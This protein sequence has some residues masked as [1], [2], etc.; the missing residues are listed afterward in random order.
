MRSVTCLSLS[1]AIKSTRVPLPMRWLLSTPGWAQ[2]VSTR[3]CLQFAQEF[4]TVDVYRGRKQA[5]SYLDDLTDGV[6]NREVLLEEMVMLWLANLNPAFA[7]YDD[8]FAHDTLKQGSAYQDIIDRLIVFFDAQPPFKDDLPLIAL[9]RAPA[10]THPDSLDAQLQF[11][12]ERWLS[13]VPALRNYVVRALNSRD[14]IKEEQRSLAAFFSAGFQGMGA[15]QFSDADIREAVRAG[16]QGA[17]RASARV[18]LAD[19]SAGDVEYEAYTLDRDWMPR[20]VLMAKNAYV[21][22]DQ[23]QRIQPRYHAAGSD[24]G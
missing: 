2:P 23:L 14:F 19:Y 1:I 22:L 8:L 6:S 11:I 7:R 12:E 15:P 16:G 17:A 18:S 20:L 9:L 3:P 5:A 13:G 21:W 10:L 4:P 24:P